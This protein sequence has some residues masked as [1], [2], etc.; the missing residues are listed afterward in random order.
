MPD[1]PAHTGP[2]TALLRELG[3]ADIAHPG[4]TLLAH[5]QRVADRTPQPQEVLAA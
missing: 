3:A 1:S 4:G 2:A 5:L